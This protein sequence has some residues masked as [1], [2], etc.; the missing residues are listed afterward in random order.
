MNI[1]A[2]SARTTKNLAVIVFL[3]LVSVAC[4]RG[5][6]TDAILGAWKGND[7]SS[8]EFLSD[9]TVIL[10][11]SKNPTLTGK[12]VRLEDDRLK[13]EFT[14]LG[15]TTAIVCRIAVK[16]DAMELINSADGKKETL[17]RQKR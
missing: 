14:M 7:G 2:I 10:T 15:T 5:P 12:W 3:L 16:G 11:S 17:N 9:G 6:A 8:V 1:S 4:G 13:M